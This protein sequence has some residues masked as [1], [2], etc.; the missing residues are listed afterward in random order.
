MKV[1]SLAR[2]CRAALYILETTRSK[3]NWKKGRNAMY[4]ETSAIS[5]E[6]FT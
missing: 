1:D 5:Y 4:M 3:R 6:E 2:P